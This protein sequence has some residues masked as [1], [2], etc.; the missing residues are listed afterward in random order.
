MEKDQPA[1][2]H[3]LLWQHALQFTRY[4]VSGGVATAVDWTAFWLLATRLQLNYQGSLVMAFVAGALV[5]YTI[6][7]LF[8][9][10]CRSRQ[11]SQQ[12]AVYFA[13]TLV[14]LLLSMACMYLCVQMFSWPKVP[15]RM[16]TT[17]AMLP[18]NFLLHKLIT[19]NRTL[20]PGRARR[21]P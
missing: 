5:N 2:P 18:V 14:T 20:F 1:S 19:F 11:V 3:Q 12:L 9:F 17:G 13:L 10:Q 16:L 15:S 8:V 21:N 7:K 4:V 6:T